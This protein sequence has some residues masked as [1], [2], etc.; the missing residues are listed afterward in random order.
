MTP[1]HGF[2]YRPLDRELGEIRLLHLQPAQD[3]NSDIFC[4]LEYCALEESQDYEALSYACGDTTLT[5]YI[6][7]NGQL[8]PVAENLKDALL[9]LRREE[10]V[11]TL[12]VDAVCIHQHDP[13][14]KSYEI[15]RMFEIYKHASRISIWLGNASHD[16]ELGFKHLGC[17]A[18]LRKQQTS[19]PLWRGWAE[20]IVRI[21]ASA[22][23]FLCIFA[24]QL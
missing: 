16:S 14:E 15:T 12:W 24:L 19:R 4:E 7:V 22:T 18:T 1:D 17:L 2:V 23:Q 9:G 21:L 5:Q 10:R 3:G 8:F 6:V 20:G 11:I 13:E